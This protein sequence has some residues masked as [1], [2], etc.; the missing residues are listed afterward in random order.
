MRVFLADGMWAEQRTLTCCIQYL[1]RYSL[2]IHHELF[3]ITAQVSPIS[4]YIDAEITEGGE[5]GRGVKS[6]KYRS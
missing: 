6:M 3:P 5:G 1:Q 4:Q 2:L